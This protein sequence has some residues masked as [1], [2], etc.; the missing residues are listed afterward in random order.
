MAKNAP[1]NT[2]MSKTTK[3]RPNVHSKKRSSNSK[4][5]KNY[6][7]KYVGQGR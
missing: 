7:K 3:K 2:F 4:T 6:R 1:T 5:S